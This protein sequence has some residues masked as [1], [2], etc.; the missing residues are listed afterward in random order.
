MGSGCRHPTAGRSSWSR[1]LGAIAIGALAVTTASAQAT[2][3]LKIRVVDNGIGIKEHDPQK[4][5]QMFVRASER[6][7]CRDKGA[8][9]PE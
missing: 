5:F 1:A 9:E 6:G 4:L 8:G 2:G 7:I 3:G